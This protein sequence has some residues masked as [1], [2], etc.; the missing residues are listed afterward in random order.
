MS[1]TYSQIYIHIVFAVK[2]RAFQ[3]SEN[4][5]TVIEKYICG[6]IDNSRCKSLAIYCNPDHTHILVSFSPLV[7]V[8]DLTRLIKA[9]SSKFINE[10]KWF[11]GKFYWQE[12]YGAFSCS[13]SKIEGVK[14]YILN[15]QR[16]HRKKTF[17]EEYISILK[18]CKIEYDNRYLFEWTDKKNN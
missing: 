18:E 17:Q 3:I 7:S 11:L 13:K 2:G 15:Q 12:G 14:D 9:N 10:N 1:N 16:H 6:I 8:S 4:H 5:R